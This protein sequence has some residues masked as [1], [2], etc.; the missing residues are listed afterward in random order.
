[1]PLSAVQ[2]VDMDGS[3]K[4]VVV[5]NHFLISSKYFKYFVS[6]FNNSVLKLTNGGTDEFKYFYVTDINDKVYATNDSEVISRLAE[7]KFNVKYTFTE[8]K[9][10]SVKVVLNV[11]DSTKFKY[12]LGGEEKEYASGLD[13]TLIFNVKTYDD[14]FT[15]KMPEKM[16]DVLKIIFEGQMVTISEDIDLCSQSYFKLIVSSY[17]GDDE[18]NIALRG[19]LIPV[20]DIG[21]DKENYVF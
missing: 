11:T 10:Y 7:T 1:M 16:E 8:N 3:G 17:N 14:Y 9:G 18:I 6:F 20:E 15:L 2:A 19:A 12:T 21:L 4:G 13:L 5:S